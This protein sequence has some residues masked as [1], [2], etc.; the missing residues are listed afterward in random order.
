[1]KKLTSLSI[2]FPCYNDQ[3]VIEELVKKVARVLAVVTSSYEII[4]VNDGSTDS[5]KAVLAKLQRDIPS[6]HVINHTSNKGYGSSLIDGFKAASKEF[7]FYTDGDGQYDVMELKNLVSTF[8]SKTDIVTGFKLRRCDPWFRKIIGAVYN[9]F[10][11]LVFQL[12]VKDVDC[13]FRLFRRKI[14]EGLSFRVTSGAFDVEF[15]KKLQKRN[16]RIKEIGVGHYP[17]RFGQSQFFSPLR[18]L[19]SLWDLLLLRLNI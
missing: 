1:M 12:K 14:L 13:D 18:I 10:V 17:R 2:V 8:D 16:A 7:I 4:V 15:I 3:W 11:R 5:S 19:R 6:L 9:Q